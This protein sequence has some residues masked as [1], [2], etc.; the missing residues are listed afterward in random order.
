MKRSKQ[1]LNT[2]LVV[3]ILSASLACWQVNRALD[4]PLTVADG[5]VVFEIRPGS[6]LSTISNELAEKGILAHPKIF[7]WYGRLAGHAGS[8]HAGEYLIE[9]G[10]SPRTL[11]DKFVSGDVRLY[12]F[13]IV[14]G[15]TYRELIEALGANPVVE[16]SITVE[17]WPR[18]HTPR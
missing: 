7:R 1:V 15:W 8:I 6:A 3:A 12:S 2:L 10:T 14:P 5:G 11:L 17:D 18:R 9:T 16:H 13:T 4:A